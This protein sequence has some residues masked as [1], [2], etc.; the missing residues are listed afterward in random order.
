MTLNELKQQAARILEIPESHGDFT[1]KSFTAR[2]GGAPR[3]N[4]G[5]PEVHRGNEFRYRTTAN[6]DAYEGEVVILCNDTGTK[7]R[8]GK[9]IYS[10]PQGQVFV[11]RYHGGSA[12]SFDYGSFEHPKL[13]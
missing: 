10:T 2:S 8:N 6:G 9:T 4:I 12:E 3:N 1:N 7:D 11:Y 13:S 5:L